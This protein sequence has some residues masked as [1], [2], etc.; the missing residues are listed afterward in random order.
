DAELDNVRAALAWM[1]KNGPT[2]N[3]IRLAVL[4]TGYWDG[5]GLLQEGTAWLRRAVAAAEP[6][7][8]PADRAAALAGLGELLVRHGDGGTAETHLAEAAALFAGIGDLIGRAHA[9]T[10]LGAATEDRGISR[11]RACGTRR[12][13]RSTARS[14]SIRRGDRSRR[15]GL[16]TTPSRGTR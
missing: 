5:H 7:A 6:V 15:R 4:L 14:G 3:F 8:R 2:A 16:R 12:P 1:Q 11:R 13:S 9:L 10:L